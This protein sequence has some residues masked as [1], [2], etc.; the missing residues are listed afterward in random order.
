MLPCARA[1]HIYHPLSLSML[2][3]IIWSVQA[4]CILGHHA[5]KLL[6]S[7]ILFLE[8]P[9]PYSGPMLFSSYVHW[10]MQHAAFNQYGFRALAQG[11]SQVN[12]DMCGRLGGQ[13][14]VQHCSFTEAWAFQ[15]CRC[16]LCCAGVTQHC[17][18]GQ[19]QKESWLRTAGSHTMHTKSMVLST[20]G[21]LGSTL[22]HLDSWSNG[23][24]KEW[25]HGA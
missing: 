11:P 9:S 6:H 2:A 10:D 12:I 22:L 25:A 17:K 14:Q 19:C 23:A 18:W 8:A 15:L 3:G 16:L 5:G 1:I 21:L 24:G 13:S 4:K 20:L 7:I